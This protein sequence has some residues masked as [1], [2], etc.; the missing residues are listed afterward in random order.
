MA[1]IG[2]LIQLPN[3]ICN[4]F[5][6]NKFHHLINIVSRLNPHLFVA[7]TIKIINKTA[8]NNRMSRDVIRWDSGV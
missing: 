8:V 4:F 1:K 3:S 7:E 5:P 6:A 2:V